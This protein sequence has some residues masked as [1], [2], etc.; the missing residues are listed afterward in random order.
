MRDESCRNKIYTEYSFLHLA[1]VLPLEIFSWQS[2]EHA[3]E[4]VVAVILDQ[5]PFG[6][7]SEKYNK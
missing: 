6:T 3:S 4:A 5:H 7:F 2:T 1:N